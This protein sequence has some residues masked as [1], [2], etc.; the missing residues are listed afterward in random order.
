MSRP[1]SQQGLTEDMFRWW[2]DSKY[3]LLRSVVSFRATQKQTRSSAVDPRASRH[4]STDLLP[5]LFGPIIIA[6]LV[7]IPELVDH[8]HACRNNIHRQSPRIKASDAETCLG[9]H[10]AASFSTFGSISGALSRRLL[11]DIVVGYCYT[12]LAR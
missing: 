7:Q 4:Q 2:T 12:A 5:I 8:E 3:L 1:L 9:S 11:I 10:F 6:V